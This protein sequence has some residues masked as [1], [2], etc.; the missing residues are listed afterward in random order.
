DVRYTLALSFTPRL[1]EDIT[2]R[3]DADHAAL[4]HQ[5]SEPGR[6]RAW[7]AADV[8][9]LHA[10]RQMREQVACG[11]LRR[12]PAV[13]AQHAVVVAVQVRFGSGRHRISIHAV[14]TGA[15]ILALTRCAQP[16]PSCNPAA[17]L[18]ADPLCQ[19]AA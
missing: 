11:V 5:G 3:I 1:G 9:D 10:W 2:G 19:A 18:S 12:S 17:G 14:R 7:P 6:N 13:R 15:D 16:G 8:E 4:R